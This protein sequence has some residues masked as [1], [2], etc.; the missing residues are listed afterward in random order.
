MTSRRELIR[1]SLA[2]GLPLAMTSRAAASTATTRETCRNAKGVDETIWMTWYDLPQS[3]E[4]EFLDWLHGSYLPRMLK[5][6]GFNWVAHYK[7]VPNPRADLA[8]YSTRMQVSPYEAPNLGRG[9][10][11][12]LMF[13]AANIAAFLPAP[14]Y[15]LRDAEPV[16]DRPKLAVRTGVRSAVLQDTMRQDGPAVA[17]RP[18][19]GPP[20]PRIHL[21]SWSTKS[22]M[23]G[24]TWK[25]NL[26]LRF[27]QFRTTPGAISARPLNAL[28]GW[29][30]AA[31]LYEFASPEAHLAFLHESE[32]PALQR[33]LAN[34][35]LMQPAK[36][37]RHAPGSPMYADR[38]WAARSSANASSSSL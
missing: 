2:L 27:P 24:E 7:R 3:S 18:Q 1:N 22:E 21:G 5:R 38:I 10:Q 36:Y 13:G 8:D 33:Y 28:L 4:A 35:E 17:T 16:E 14:S 12:V 31:V 11:Y 23:E 20:G 19:P 37:T 32:G 25:W 30:R 34:P 6:P 26:G 9:I 15:D 29:I